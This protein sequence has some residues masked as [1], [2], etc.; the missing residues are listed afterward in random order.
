MA[1]RSAA[2]PLICDPSART[3]AA[4][5]GAPS[6]PASRQFPTES[7]FSSANPGGS[8]TLWQVAHVGLARCNSNGARTVLAARGVAFV[9]SSSEGTLGGAGGGGVLRKVLRTYLP[10]K[11]GE[12]LVATEVI[13]RILPCPSSPRRLGSV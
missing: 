2:G 5:S 9:L 6:G 10:R 4:S 1:C 12:V 3:P 13:D 7:K 8:I 11:T